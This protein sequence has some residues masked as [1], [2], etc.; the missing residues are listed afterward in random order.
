[1]VDCGVAFADDTTPGIDL[2]VPNAAF[3]EEWRAELEGIV[4][5]HAHEDHLG[6]VAH[7]W[8][9][10]RCPIYATPFA[11]DL[12][13]AKLREVGLQD[14]AKITITP[15]KSRFS[16]GPFD[17]EYVT[18]THSIPEANALA[19]HTRFGT[20]LHT[21][22]WKLDPDPLIGELSDETRLESLGK[23]G[24]L[25]LVGDSTNVFA[26]GHSGSEA[27]V[28]HALVELFSQ[29][30]KRIVATCFASNVARV[31]SIV[32]AAIE[33]GRRVALVGRSLL[34]ISEIARNNGLLQGIPPFISDHDAM[35]LPR[36]RVVF[37][38]TGCQ[39]EPRA[40]LCRIAEENH[41]H[42]KLDK[43]DVVAFSS[44]VI[45]GNEK[46]IARLQNALVRR[47]VEI[48]TER[49]APIHASGHPARD[50]LKTMYRLVK[51]H[52]A[53]PMHGEMRHLVAH[54]ELA[55]EC[56]AKYALVVENGAV[57][58]LAPGKPEI[59]DHVFTGKLAVEGDR[60]VPLDSVILRDRRRMVHNGAAVVTLVMD[61]KGK[62]L[63][64][65]Q[66]S[67]H[68][69]LDDEH[70]PENHNRVVDAIE[71][72][73]RKLS[74]R[75]RRSDDAVREEVRIAVRRSMNDLFN[76]KPLT[77]VHLVRI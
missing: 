56:G 65:V 18:L 11:A 1:M 64:D 55:K 75:E 15:P 5:T 40:A 30:D 39:G 69:L 59:V 9:K 26:D 21:G 47:G 17:L 73:I 22:D 23:K 10:L 51:P 74:E 68:G 53:I 13:K 27:D 76:K 67:A 70:E 33:N 25:A 72:T 48:I 60:L 49:E 4:I 43:G 14:K 77:D 61:R 41:P 7:L 44:R 52:I 58:K 32:H 3:I 71:A 20:V 24:V 12:L 62:L 19:I 66:L 16:V 57:L 29:Y 28:R 8:P 31:E 34:R 50:E 36:N 2:L 37:I 46:E 38:S 63:G 42:V 54:V 45:P 35:D 6:A